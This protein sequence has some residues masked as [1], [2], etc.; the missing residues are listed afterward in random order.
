MSTPM[1]WGDSEIQEK[2]LRPVGV[3]KRDPDRA[4]PQL[5]VSSAKRSLRS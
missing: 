2:V 3:I 1:F 5:M 4:K